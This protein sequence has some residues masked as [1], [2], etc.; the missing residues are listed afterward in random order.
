VV[1]GPLIAQALTGL[2]AGTI[3]LA[4]VSLIKKMV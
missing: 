4:G 3:V 1:I 2:L